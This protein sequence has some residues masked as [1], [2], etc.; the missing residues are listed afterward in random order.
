MQFTQRIRSR[1][2]HLPLYWAAATSHEAGVKLPLPLPLPLLQLL[3]L[4]YI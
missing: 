1:V 2:K 4:L 3:L